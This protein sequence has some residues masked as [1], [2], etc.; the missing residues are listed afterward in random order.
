VNVAGTTSTVWDVIKPTQETIAGTSIPKS[1]E[2]ATGAGNFWVAPNATKHMTEYLM[3]H[4]TSFSTSV[5]S[6]V[7][8]TDFY[9]AVSLAASQ[10]IKYNTLMQFGKWELIFAPPRAGAALPVIKHAL[11][12]P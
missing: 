7:M 12:K 2:L 11:Y 10:G 1:F 6:Q 4:G 5:T 8:L 3:S 9:Q